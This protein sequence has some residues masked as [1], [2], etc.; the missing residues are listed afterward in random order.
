[1]VK[2]YLQY[3]KTKPIDM[4]NRPK[5]YVFSNC[6]L[7]LHGFTHYVWDEYSNSDNKDQKEKPKDKN[8]DFMDLVRYCCMLKPKYRQEVSRTNTNMD[9]V[10]GY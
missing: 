4:G 5:L 2:R 10:T 3:D 8:K 7:F 6:K 1:M 9:S